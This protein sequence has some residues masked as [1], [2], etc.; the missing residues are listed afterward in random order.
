MFFDCREGVKEGGGE[1]GLKGRRG[2]KKGRWKRC[3]ASWGEDYVLLYLVFL[4]PQLVGLK[5]KSGKK[6]K[7]IT[8]REKKK[9]KEGRR[10]VRTHTFCHEAEFCYLPRALISHRTCSRHELRCAQ[11]REKRR[12]RRGKRKIWTREEE[13]KRGERERRERC[14]RLHRV[15]V[16][17]LMFLS[18]AHTPLPLR[19]RSMRAS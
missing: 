18:C 12:G 17:F 15:P 13:R 5:E 6:K 7:A 11:I 8:E 14:G 16:L 3:Y 2:G 4:Q 1:K 10:K 9:A 19:E